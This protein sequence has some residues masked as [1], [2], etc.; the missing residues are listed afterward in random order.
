M[1]MDANLLIDAAKIH[2]AQGMKELAIACVHAALRVQPGNVEAHNLREEYR[3]SGCFSDWIGVHAR[4]HPQDDIFRFFANHSQSFNPVRDYL[5]D[6][7]RSALEL[8]RLV[9]PIGRPLHAVQSFLEFACGHGRLTRHLVKELP[10]HRLTVSDVV[11]GSVDFLRDTLGVKG[12]YSSSEPQ[13]LK[14]PEHY[15]MIFVLSLFT[16]LPPYLGALASRAIRTPAA[17]WL[18][19]HQHAWREM[20]A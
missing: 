7:W 4:I 8:H 20:C 15:E 6:G 1:T 14:A 2:F 9:N 12:F 19:D 5:S 3:L 11:P 16:H 17:P 18:S 13:A 10:P